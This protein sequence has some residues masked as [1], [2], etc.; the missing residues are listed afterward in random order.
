M[1]DKI[2][3]FFQQKKKNAKFMNAGKGYKLTDSTS[4]RLA[5]AE[6]AKPVLRAEPTEEAKVAGQAAL[7]R[8][9][10]KKV[11]KPK[12]NTS[13]AAIQA[14]VKREM[15]LEKKAQQNLQQA[16]STA[17]KEEKD[18]IEDPS[19]YAV[20][21]VFFR[22]PYISD[23][24]LPRDQ[25][26]KKIREFLYDERGGE[27]PGLTASL[28]IQN[29]NSGKEKIENC[30]ETLGKY[31]ENIIKDPVMEK[32]WK[33]R[34]SN[35]IFQEKILPVEG[36][37]DFLKAAGFD[38]KVLRH[39]ENEEDF[40]VWN[41]DNCNIEE[42]VILSDALKSAEQIPIELDRNLQVLMPCQARVRNELPPSFFTISPEEIKRE[43]QLRTEA[44]ERN[45]MLRT[46]AMREKD[47]QRILRRYKFAVLRIKFPDGLILQ[48]TFMV[49]EKFRNVLEFVTENLAYH[50]VPFSLMTPDGIKLVE[51]CLE[52]TL[53]EL[54]LIPTAILEF[55]WNTSDGSSCSN[56]PTGYLKEEILSY[57]QSI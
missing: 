10:A 17:L 21:D 22:C 32:Y 1:A 30:V 42:L 18:R 48:G 23:E 57:I 24:I 34:M 47:E 40:L 39:N 49:H 19:T 28:I 11:D 36:A 29:C 3:S 55:S 51:E 50:E 27:E 41:P 16:G 44:V 9:E 13:Y 4:T 12:F 25:W 52:K 46:K 7:A 56:M 2:K 20:I 37:L 14:R 43:Q 8:L 54:R 35:R 6:P 31:L 38:Q 15:E 5:S 26:K 33:I 53:L 45:Q